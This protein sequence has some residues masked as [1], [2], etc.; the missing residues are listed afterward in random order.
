MSEESKVCRAARLGELIGAKAS[1][2]FIYRSLAAEGR[3]QRAA[4][5]NIGCLVEKQAA[6]RDKD[7]R[8][9]HR[10]RAVA[11]SDPFFLT[12]GELRRE[13]GGVADEQGFGLVPLAAID[14]QRLAAFDAYA[15][16]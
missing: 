12:V 3:V 16:S 5:A 6:R 7:A 1:K 4:A 11:K 9:E 15:N 13:I 2:G 14:S 10:A 8:R